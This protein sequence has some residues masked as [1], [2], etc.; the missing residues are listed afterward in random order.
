MESFYFGLTEITL[1]KWSLEYKV[2]YE[3]SL[4]RYKATWNVVYESAV[5]NVPTVV[6]PDTF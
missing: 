1:D 3:D 4:W 2:L 5:S 6:S